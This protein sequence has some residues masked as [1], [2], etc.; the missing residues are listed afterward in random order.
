MVTEINFDSPFESNDDQKQRLKRKEVIMTLRDGKNRVRFYD[1]HGKQSNT[2][3]YK[4]KSI[5][6]P[7]GECPLCVLKFKKSTRYFLKV[8]DRLSDSVKV[9]DF[10]TRIKKQ[11]DE[12]I[13]DFKTERPQE[14]FTETDVQ[15][16]RTKTGA[17]P[18]DILKQCLAAGLTDGLTKAADE[19]L[20][21]NDNID[22]AE[23]AGPWTPEEIQRLIDES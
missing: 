12:L 7:A 11:L 10:G 6:C 21:Q 14:R 22:L 1:L 3:W 16:K 23:V 17:S 15:I 9:L 4:G 5:R 13:A 2:H 19:E 8:I 20:I 18:E